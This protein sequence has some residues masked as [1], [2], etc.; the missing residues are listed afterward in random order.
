M[1]PK[2]TMADIIDVV[3]LDINNI[4]PSDNTVENSRIRPFTPTC[5]W[6]YTLHVCKTR[7]S[8]QEI[9]NAHTVNKKPFNKKFPLVTYYSDQPLTYCLQKQVN[10]VRSVWQSLYGV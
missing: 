7:F 4:L 9:H 3:L 8:V 1:A 6:A 2:P 5:T 10:I